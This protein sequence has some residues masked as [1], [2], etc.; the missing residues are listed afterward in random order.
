M[1]AG[2]HQW[3]RFRHVP[4]AASGV[5]A[6]LADAED[7]DVVAKSG[8]GVGSGADCFGDPFGARVA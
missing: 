7:G 6:E 4:D 8:L 2:E 5:A 3:P 1:D